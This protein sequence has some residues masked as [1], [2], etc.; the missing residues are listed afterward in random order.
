VGHLA[1]TDVAND[2][3]CISEEENEESRADN[4]DSVDLE[5]VFN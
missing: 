4:K 1:R 5:E 2:G 3:E